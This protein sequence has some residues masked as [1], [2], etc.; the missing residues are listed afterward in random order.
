MPSSSTSKK[1]PAK[2]GNPAKKAASKTTSSRSKVTPKAT[3]QKAQTDPNDPYAPT[4]WGSGGNA[5]GTHELEVPSGQKCLVKRPGMEALMRQ[6]ILRDVD[7]LTSLV[8]QKIAEKGGKA[9]PGTEVDLSK[10]LDQPEKLDAIIH[11]VDRAVVACVIKPEVVMTPSD[12]T[13]R[14]DGVVYAD[15]IDL[16]DKFF[17]FNYVVGGSSDLEQFRLEL[18]ESVGSL[19]PVQA[20]EGEAQ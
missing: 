19:D 7:T 12:E 8:D 11:T 2:S 18:D 9:K 6:G 17:I 16:I 10:M 3:S 5:Q 14:K 15:M 20:D 13:R 1:N 4:A